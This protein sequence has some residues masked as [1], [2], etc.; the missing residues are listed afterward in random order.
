MRG[1]HFSDTSN[2]VGGMNLCADE[3]E[4]RSEPSSG[5]STRKYRT[6]CRSWHHSRQM[7]AMSRGLCKWRRLVAAME[8]RQHATVLLQGEQFLGSA[9]N[10]LIIILQSRDSSMF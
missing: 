7:S 10:W 3:M 4:S 2:K 5:N 1:H 6:I 8:S 9:T